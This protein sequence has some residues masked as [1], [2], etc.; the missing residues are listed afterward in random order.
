M[1]Q[2]PFRALIGKALENVT[3]PVRNDT[4]II[5]DLKN[6]GTIF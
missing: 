2:Y 5:Q 3:V 4:V 1:F 6:E